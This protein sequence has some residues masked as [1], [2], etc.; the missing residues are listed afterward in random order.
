M[1]VRN[2]TATESDASAWGVSAAFIGAADELQSALVAWCRVVGD[3]ITS[4]EISPNALSPPTSFLPSRTS[5]GT[6]SST[7]RRSSAVS[8]DGH[9]YPSQ[10]RP[11]KKPPLWRRGSLP[12]SSTALHTIHTPRSPTPKQLSL[13]DIAIMPTQR[14]ARYVM[15]YRGVCLFNG[16]FMSSLN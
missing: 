13:Q 10:L 3:V 15:L 4:P 2:R 14:V 12:G 16:A 6:F 11:S 7:T 8:D 1:S 5:S 9:G